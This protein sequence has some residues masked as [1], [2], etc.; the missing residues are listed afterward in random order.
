MLISGKKARMKRGASWKNSP[1]LSIRN[2]LCF[3]S[4]TDIYIFTLH[5]PQ[6]LS[7]MCF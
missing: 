4:F 3:M 5:L 6:S 7:F 1:T 2:R